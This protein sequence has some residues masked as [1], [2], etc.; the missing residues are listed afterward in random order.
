M[1]VNGRR[2]CRR[3]LFTA[4]Q[5]VFFA[6]RLVG[7]RAVEVKLNA[8]FFF[9]CHSSDRPP[10]WPISARRTRLPRARGRN[11]LGEIEKKKQ[12]RNDCERAEEKRERTQLA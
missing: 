8:V 7:R 5:C 3:C 10:A 6:D 9:E 1:S 2:R 12:R 11:F 4:F